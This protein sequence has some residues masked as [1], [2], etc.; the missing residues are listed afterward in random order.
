MAKKILLLWAYWQQNIGDEALLEA[1]IAI[2]NKE[3]T[4]T[5]YSNS[6]TPKD[7]QEEYPEV[8][9]FHTNIRENLKKFLKFFF[10][11]NIIVYWGGSLLV[12]L[13]MNKLNKRTPLI[14][15]FL[16]NGLGR[17]L[18][19]KIVYLWV[20][21]EYVSSWLSSFLMK[22]LLK[23]W[24]LFYMRDEFSKKVI[25]DYWVS[26][27]KTHLIPDIV[28]TLES[29]VHLNNS[30]W[31]FDICI[32]PVCR[33]PDRE[34]NYQKY[35]ESLW[36]FI[37]SEIKKWNKI[38]LCWM[39]FEETDDLN[40]LVA[41][42]DIISDI[43]IKEKWVIERIWIIWEYL[44]P[45]EF[46]EAVSKFDIVYSSRFHGLIYSI[47]SNIPCVSL[48][49]FPKSKYLLEESGLWDLSLNETTLDFSK[50]ENIQKVL[51]E[52]YAW[53]SKK[54]STIKKDKNLIFQEKLW[55]LYD[56]LS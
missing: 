29:K 45:K 36:S 33:V 18:W 23:F 54:I 47:N 1:S 26:R 5:I 43:E 12:E 31:Y 42:N 20:W 44:T 49:D 14:R 9:F 15:M 56:L 38:T 4:H 19:K 34:K 11:S 13:K 3:N 8:I 46:S 41:I 37:I 24:N 52:E 32:I 17:M 21:A 39:R 7:S 2:L 27:N 48:S 55:D 6:M 53:F 35:V 10:T 30:T 40:D 22:T 50:L 16:L 28:H 25:E 51:E